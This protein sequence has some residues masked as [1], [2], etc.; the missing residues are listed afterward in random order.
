[1]E[2]LQAL[3]SITINK[4][5]MKGN[6]FTLTKK[7]NKKTNLIFLG[8]CCILKKNNIRNLKKIHASDIAVAITQCSTFQKKEHEKNVKI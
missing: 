2:K 8:K 6:I 3:L 4:I 5:D 7:N 1:M